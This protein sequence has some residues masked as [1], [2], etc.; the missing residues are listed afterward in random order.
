[1]RTLPPPSDAARL[2]PAIPSGLMTP[3]PETP[4]PIEGDGRR[5]AYPDRLTAAAET[6]RAEY[7][8]AM[9]RRALA[10]AEARRS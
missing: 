6:D 9:I 10:S 1:M 5:I 3:P 2:P 7:L 8:R 4:P